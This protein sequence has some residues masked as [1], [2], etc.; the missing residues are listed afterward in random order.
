MRTLL[1][2]DLITKLNTISDNQKSVLVLDRYGKTHK[3][4]IIVRTEDNVFY[5]FMYEN[6]GCDL[7]VDWLECALEEEASE[8]KWAQNLFDD[9]RPK[10]GDCEIMFVHGT[11]HDFNT[12]IKSYLRYDIEEKDDVIILK[13]Q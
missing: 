8:S 6:D 9:D 11:R 13:C 10:F 1:V 12:S 7:N 2:S 4:D 3:L 5:L